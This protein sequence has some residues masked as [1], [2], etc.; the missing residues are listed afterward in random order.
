MR[1]FSRLAIMASAMVMMISC[2]SKSK[3][4]YETVEDDPL[5]T[6]IYTLENGLKLYLTV[7]DEQPRIQTYIAVHA[8][9]KDDP[10]ENTGLAHYLEHLMFKGTNHF[11]TWNYEKESVELKKIDELY[12]QYN[13]TTDA[14]E[15]KAIYHQI[16]SV[17]YEASRYAIPNEYDKLMAAI[18]ADGTNAYTSNDVTCY[19]EDIPSN[20]L[21]NWAKIQADRF[22]NMVIRLFHTELEAVYEEKNIGM[23]SDQDKI[24][25]AMGKA[26]YPNHPYGTQTV[27][28]EQEH[29]KNPSIVKIREYFNNFYRP[30][31]VAICMSGDFDPDE[32]VDVI[33]K[34]FGAWKANDSIVRKEVK[35]Q[36]EIT[37]PIIKEVVGEE[38]ENVWLAWRAPA[39]KDKDQVVLDLISSM[40]SNG[41]AGLFDLDLNQPQKVLQ[42]AAFNYSLEQA[43]IFIVLAYPMPGQTL[44]EARQLLL[45]E[46]E[47]LK[48]GKFDDRLLSSAITNHKLGRERMLEENSNRASLYVNA[49]V[50]GQSWQD[51]VAADKATEKVTKDDV[52]RVANKYFG[53]NYAAI[54]K[55]Q[56]IDNTIIA[57]EKPEIN[58]VIM[59]RDSVS[60]LLAEVQASKVKDITP[61]FV[62]YKKELTFGKTDKGIE[63][64]NK[65]NELNNI[66]ELNYIYEVGGEND[67]ELD[68][69][70]RYFDYLGTSKMSAEEIKMKFY[71]LGCN[72]GISCGSKRTYIHLSGLEANRDEAVKLMEEVLADL[73]ADDEALNNVK[74][75]SLQEREVMLSEQD[76][77]FTLLRRYA[78]YGAD[79]VKRITLTN[80]QIMGL[81]AQKLVDKIKSLSTLEHRITYYGKAEMSDVVKMLNAEHKTADKLVAA[82]KDNNK[83]Y[84]LPTPENV[85]YLAHYSAPNC[86]IAF[87]TTLDKHYDPTLEPI[88][89][90][91][92]EYF[93]GGMNTIVFQEIRERRGLAYTCNSR[94]FGTSFTDDPYYF[95]S[96]AKTQVDKLNDCMKVYFEIIENM[97]KAEAAFQI[98]KQALL[99]RLS[100]QRTVRDAVITDYF[101]ALDHGID[102]DIN[103]NIYD[104]VL[105]MSLD[106]VVKFQEQNVKGRTYTYCIV[107]DRNKVDM[108]TVK[109]L[110]NVKEVSI[111]DICGFYN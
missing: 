66:F 20:Q 17:S 21:D 93:G 41:T 77:C 111:K 22:Q 26:L 31:N 36:P 34:Y 88:R 27:I 23:S 80:D 78:L 92:N 98:A 57:I 95:T 74:M 18:G 70:A 83:T 55:R 79:A 40:L 94:F 99:T 71:A 29:L 49:F 91:Y 1:R 105:K 102:Y 51:V 8:G 2:G 107:A 73:K 56:G 43:G 5:N 54:N 19:T 39:A 85:V 11:G 52:V 7:N 81:E 3:Y 62:D 87:N 48:S 110:G 72:A 38:A 15:R 82:N 63:V 44:D 104:A 35:P 109:S 84:I 97:P 25:E 53:N 61:V 30:N 45:D 14:A 9:G 13:K 106:D 67:S 50:N 69:A 103:K 37:A 75:A 33:N 24:F 100:T 6:K 12:E 108:N 28:G 60:A 10:A 42:S 59:N 101:D 4:K 16:D 86:A 47:K 89:V 68:F 76:R 90:M 32:V 46:I 64:I 96:S 58:P 65:K